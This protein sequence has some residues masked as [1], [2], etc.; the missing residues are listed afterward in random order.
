MA[1]GE[2]FVEGRDALGQRARVDVMDLDDES[3]RHF[4]V[5]MLKHTGTVT[6]VPA[7]NPTEIIYKQR[8]VALDG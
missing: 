2:I 8:K 7:E 4:V 1:R 6:Y 5:E 3:F